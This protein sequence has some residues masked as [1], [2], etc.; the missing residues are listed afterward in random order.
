MR[1]PEDDR[2]GVS[3]EFAVALPAVL[4]CLALCVGGV[5]GAAQ[6]AALAGSAAVAARLA[7]RG[8]DPVGAG[9]PAGSSF[10]I[11]REGKVVCVSSTAPD[12]AILSRLGIRLRARACA[13]DEELAP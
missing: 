11:E 8:D 5:Y 3:A 10:G 4:G 12:G 2:G 6:Y 9:A 13:L 1:C 7:A